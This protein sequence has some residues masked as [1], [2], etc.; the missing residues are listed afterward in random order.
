MSKG[1]S[2]SDG[3]AKFQVV[4]RENREVGQRVMKLVEEPRLSEKHWFYM[5]VQSSGDW[6]GMEEGGQHLTFQKEGQFMRAR[7]PDFS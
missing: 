1:T 2:S 7:V 6:E 4:N 5:K 3:N